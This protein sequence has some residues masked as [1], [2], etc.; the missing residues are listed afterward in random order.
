[1]KD[2]RYNRRAR[3]TVEFFKSSGLMN[4]TLKT[5]EVRTREQFSAVNAS[6]S[7]E[8]FLKLETIDN[9]MLF[10]AVTNRT[11]PLLT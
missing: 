9:F 2:L 1:M 8:K 10:N 6:H 11:F 5:G 3:D 7:M 4:T